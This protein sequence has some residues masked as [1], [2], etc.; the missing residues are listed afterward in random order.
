MAIIDPGNPAATQ[1]A[2]ELRGDYVKNL[3]ILREAYQKAIFELLKVGVKSYTIDT[4]QNSQ[5]VSRQD[6]PA[7][8]SSLKTINDLIAGEES[9]TG[10]TS[11][12]PGQL[13]QVVPF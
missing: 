13:V 4:G 3:D 1:S 7:L 9:S 2:S 12:V 10:S 8:T 6:I 5:T 11:V